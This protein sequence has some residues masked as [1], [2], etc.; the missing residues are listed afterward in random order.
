[1][2]GTIKIVEQRKTLSKRLVD[3]AVSFWEKE[4]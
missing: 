4:M 3:L 1:M 2:G